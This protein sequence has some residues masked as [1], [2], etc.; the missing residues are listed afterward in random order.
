[1]GSA[2]RNQFDSGIFEK[3]YKSYISTSLKTL[4]K[5]EYIIA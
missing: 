2:Y 5:N 4:S 3:L 1:M